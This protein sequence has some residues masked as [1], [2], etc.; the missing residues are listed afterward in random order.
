MDAL[1]VDIETER[2]SNIQPAN[3]KATRSLISAANSK[4]SSRIVGFSSE[5]FNRRQPLFV[6][7]MEF[8]VGRNG[9][10]TGREVRRSSH[11]QRGRFA[12]AERRFREQEHAERPQER[13]AIQFCPGRR[14]DLRVYKQP[15]VCSISSIPLISL[16]NSP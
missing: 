15:R 5:R 3:S 2:R 10:A 12:S 4:A 1:S 7:S 9:A 6:P 11:L 14:N 13:L 16:S 8:G